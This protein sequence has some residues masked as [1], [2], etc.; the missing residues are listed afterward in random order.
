LGKT[1][2]GRV[3]HRHLYSA[4][5]EQLQRDR[6]RHVECLELELEHGVERECSDAGHAN[7]DTVDPDIH[8]RCSRTK[9]EPDSDR[10]EFRRRKRHDFFRY[11]KR[12]WL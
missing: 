2:N 5:S 3:V 6:R 10:D 8:E 4:L 12:D 1:V 9:S 7:G 11:G